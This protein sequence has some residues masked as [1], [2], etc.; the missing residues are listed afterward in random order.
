MRAA[1]V[2]GRNN[3]GAHAADRLHPALNNYSE[4]KVQFF[5]ISV[6]YTYCLLFLFTQVVEIEQDK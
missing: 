5:N 2:K 4:K 1:Q 3:F 6:R